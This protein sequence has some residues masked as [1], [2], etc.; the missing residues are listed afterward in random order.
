MTEPP[1]VVILTTKLPEDIWLA[2]KLADV[3]RIVGV[4]FPSGVRYREYG[5][6]NVLRKRL[7]T[8]GM[9][10]VANQ[11]LLVLYRHLCERK[12]DRRAVRKLFTGK[13][14]EHLEV[15]TDILEVDRVNSAV[16]ADFI[17]SRAPDVVVVSGAPLLQSVIRQAAGGRIMNLHPGFAPRYRGRYGA[18]WPIH[19]G[20]P[21]L[22]G[23]TVHFVDSG[24]DTG[25]ILAR[26]RVAFKP[27]DTLKMITYRQ[28]KAG[29]ELLAR[30]LAE[31]H[32]AAPL[33]AR[34][35]TSP[36]RN[37]LAPGLT[38]YLKARRWLRKNKDWRLSRV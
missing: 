8:Q 32:T 9:G 18:L 5:L 6:R 20:E 26:E 38:H 31:W 22:V 16:T 12:R 29:A 24:I 34:D 28:Q 17:R 21:A 1:R 25:A 14:T 37:Y 11:A 2:N 19:N 30:C 4:V 3:A 27:D 33:A 23:V 36:S 13:S 10:A 7:R 15:E 35:T